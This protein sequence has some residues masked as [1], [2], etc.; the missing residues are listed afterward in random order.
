ML[1]SRDYTLDD[2]RKLVVETGRI[3]NPKHSYMFW[4]HIWV[5]EGREPLSDRELIHKGIHMVQEDE[6]NVVTMLLFFVASVVFGIPVYTFIL[7]I[8]WIIIFWYTSLF[9][10]LELISVL[11]LG[12]KYNP[13][14]QE[15][16]E[17]QG[18]V[19]YMKKREMF[20]WLKY[21]IK[22]PK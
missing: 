18:N 19:D 17:N 8:L 7:G 3:S 20:S 6:V 4:G 2:L 1:T 14:E 9:Y 21:L 13:L 11:C 22:N 10:I 5:R 16:L 12:Y 15:A